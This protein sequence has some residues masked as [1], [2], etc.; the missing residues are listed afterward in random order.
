MSPRE[1]EALREYI[2]SSLRKGWIKE[3]KSP[4]GAP[5]LFAPKADGG[6][7]LRVDY[8]GLNEITI[9]NR[10]ALPRIDEMLD[11]LTGAKKF[12]K[13]DVRDAYHT[14]RRE[15]LLSRPAG[16]RNRGSWTTSWLHRKRANHVAQRP[17][18]RP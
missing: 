6:L 1:L 3:S 2:G 15:C 14:P 11:R 16:A 4:A 17:E 12:S 8:R 7:R 5:V 9:K 18:L 13:I 10:Y